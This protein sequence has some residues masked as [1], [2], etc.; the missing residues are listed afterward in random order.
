MATIIDQSELLRRALRYLDERRSE[1]PELP[2]DALLDEAG[3]RFNLG[4]ADAE[5]LARLFR[6]RK[7]NR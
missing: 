1:A 4:P 7:P 3:M 6:E 2:I 5:N